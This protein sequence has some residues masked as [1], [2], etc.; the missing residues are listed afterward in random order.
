[1]TRD[2][3]VRLQSWITRVATDCRQ[4]APVRLGSKGETRIGNKGSLAIYTDGGWQDYAAGTG[5]NDVCSLLLHLLDTSPIEARRHA[6]EWLNHHPGTGSC[7]SAPL[8]AQ[9]VQARDAR[10]AD[11]AR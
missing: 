9:E 5:G 2:Q 4:G 6:I 3:L 1:L 11:Y 10:Y 7:T 8:S